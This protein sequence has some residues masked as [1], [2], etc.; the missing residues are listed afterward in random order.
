LIKHGH[1]VS[2]LRSRNESKVDFH[3]LAHF[4]KYVTMDDIKYTS[5]AWDTYRELRNSDVVLSISAGI[6]GKFGKFWMLSPLLVG[7]PLFSVASGSDLSELIMQ[8]NVTAWIYR[9]IL[10][11]SVR[12]ITHPF[13][14]IVKN[15]QQLDL[16]KKTSNIPYPLFFS[17]AKS[18]RAV[19]RQGPLRVLHATNLDW[20][21]KDTGSWRNS[22]K[23]N[24][25]F[26]KGILDAMKLGADIEC[27]ITYR[28]PDREI[29]KQWI[30][31]SGF[32]EKFKWIG[33][34]NQLAVQELIAE[35]DLVVDQFTVGAF[36]LIALEAMS[37][38]TP[39]LLRLDDQY[40]R[41]LYPGDEQVP[42]I[43]L[44]N[45]EEITRFLVQANPNELRYI[46][47][48][49][50]EWVLRNHDIDAARFAKLFE[51]I[52]ELATSFSGEGMPR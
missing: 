10:R 6:I 8:K 42:V 47:L 4:P 3:D 36:G 16:V 14:M 48:Q 33:E 15:L 38:G 40:L 49:A 29:A 50:R 30:D 35:V 13:P 22:S 45:A 24:D 44:T 37:L 27:L 25:I 52:E 23:G 28:G 39:V 20:G 2:I 21:V 12:I 26:I 17:D 9:W 19:P 46:G 51:L 32:S 18:R 1:R 11:R 31:D 34:V 43:N 5:G 7:K 41:D